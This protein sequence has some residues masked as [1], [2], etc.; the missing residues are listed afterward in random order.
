MQMKSDNY[1]LLNFKINPEVKNQF[2][3]LCRSK[4]SNMTTELNRMIYE[5]ISVNKSISTYQRPLEWLIGKG[6]KNS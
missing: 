3:Y 1:R 6:S 5:F 2:Y 4:R